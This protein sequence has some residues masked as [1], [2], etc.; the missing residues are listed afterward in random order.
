LTNEKN[1]GEKMAW[2]ASA[3][4]P[5]PATQLFIAAPRN[6]NT[7]QPMMPAIATGSTQGGSEKGG[8]LG[9]GLPVR[10]HRSVIGNHVV[11]SQGG[12]HGQ[13]QK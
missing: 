2:R 7:E 11:F 1:L 4:P 13:K 5:E 8:D 10:G 12:Q 3:M 9:A 6:S